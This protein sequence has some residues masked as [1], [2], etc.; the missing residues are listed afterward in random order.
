MTVLVPLAASAGALGLNAYNASQIGARTPHATPS[1]DAAEELAEALDKRIEHISP[2]RKPPVLGLEFNA[3]GDKENLLDIMKDSSKYAFNG[4]RETNDG[5]NIRINPNTDRAYLA[6][7][8]G[9]AATDQ[10][11]IGR[12]IRSARGNKALTRSLAAAAILGGTG[13]SAMEAGD[14]DLDTAVALTYA[15]AIPQ[16]A[17]EILATKNGLAIMDTAGMRATLGQRGKLAAGLL[18]YLG[19]PLLMGA[20]TNLVGNQFDED[21]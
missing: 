3:P 12:L 5:Y 4:R 15:A 16:I 18:S 19:A 6:H 7:E 14:E 11:D 1:L 8:L 10:T 17:D 13:L 9:H 20:T 2:G 21:V